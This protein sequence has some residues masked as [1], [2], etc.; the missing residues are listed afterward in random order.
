M[1]EIN[2]NLNRDIVYH[3]D[4]KYHTKKVIQIIGKYDKVKED[5]FISLLNRD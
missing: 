5:Y 4:R 3:M 1:H 2:L